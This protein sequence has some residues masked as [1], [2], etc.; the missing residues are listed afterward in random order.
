VDGDNVCTDN[1]RYS[2][3]DSG[4]QLRFTEFEVLGPLKG[5]KMAKALKSYFK[6][7]NLREVSLEQ[8]SINCP[9][10]KR[11]C[12]D[13]ILKGIVQLKKQFYGLAAEADRRE[14]GE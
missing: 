2:L 10:E 11:E 9:I 13:N 14:T 5:T 12:L 7:R 1:I 8:I 3:S 4:G 6:G